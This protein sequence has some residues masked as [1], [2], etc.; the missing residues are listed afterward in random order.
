M[1]KSKNI[2]D[3]EKE[4]DKKFDKILKDEETNQDPPLP[5]SEELK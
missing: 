2:E 4:L 3:F 5:I 1:D